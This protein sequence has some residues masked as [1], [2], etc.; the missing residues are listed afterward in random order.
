MTDFSYKGE[1]GKYERKNV[2]IPSGRFAL[3]QVLFS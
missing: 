3:I 2:V 1:Q